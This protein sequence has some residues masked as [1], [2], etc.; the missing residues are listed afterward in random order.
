MSTPRR[1]KVIEPTAMLTVN[2][3][4]RATGTA[5]IRSMRA[6]GKTS[7]SRRPCASAMTSVSVEREPTMRSSHRTIRE[8]I[9]S[10]CIFGRA[11]S[12]G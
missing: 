1:P 11:T 6:I 8:V 5:L 4:G 7:T 2:I 9:C 3:T 12:T 10:T